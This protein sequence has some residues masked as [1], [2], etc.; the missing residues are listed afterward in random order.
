MIYIGIALITKLILIPIGKH[1]GDAML[2]AAV[3]I[4]ITGALILGV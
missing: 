2:G 3:T 4:L 1:L